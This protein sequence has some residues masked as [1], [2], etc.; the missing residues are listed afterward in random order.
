MINTLKP[1]MAKYL[2]I[3]FS[4]LGLVGF[5]IVWYCMPHK[6]EIDSIWQVVFKLLMFLF[7]VLA[8]AFFPNKFKARYLLLILPFFIFTGYLIPRI[9]YF[10][11]RAIPMKLIP[12]AHLELY[13]LLFVMVFPAIVMT[14]CMAYRLGGGTPGN[15]IKIA[16]SAVIIL[17]SGWL[18]FMW[19]TI[20][21][22]EIPER[23][24]YAH[25]IE[26]IIGHFPTYVET[27]IFA[28]AHIPLLVILNVLPLDKWIAKIGLIDTPGK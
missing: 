15:V 17:F 27:I 8:V 28:A 19:Y 25:H 21:P 4:I 6:G 3:V 5:L 16:F 7:I 23:I 11:F 26:V 1:L 14:V 13:T 20:N 18:D 24:V 9:T 10:A 22:V 12:D 2:W